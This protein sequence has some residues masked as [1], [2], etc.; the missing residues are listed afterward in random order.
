MYIQTCDFSYF[1]LRLAITTLLPIERDD[2]A[3]L[4]CTYERWIHRDSYLELELPR[5]NKQKTVDFLC[6]RL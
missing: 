1:L 2:R 6:Y 5:I 4:L 3:E